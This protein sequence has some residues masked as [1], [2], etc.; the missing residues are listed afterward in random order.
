MTVSTNGRSHRSFHFW[1]CLWIWKWNRPSF[2]H[3]HS[4]SFSSLLLPVNIL[5]LLLASFSIPSLRV[6]TI[7]T[8]N[9]AMDDSVGKPNYKSKLSDRLLVS[10]FHFVNRFIRWDKLPPIIGA[11]N[12][13]ALRVELRQYNLHDGYASAT[14][15]GDPNSEPM[16]DKRF[17]NARNSDGKFN[18]VQMPL[19][20][21]TGMRLG[22]NFPRVLTPK[23]TEE[24]LWTPN[25]RML[26]Q[27]FMAR[28]A[29]IPAT[30]LNLLAAAWIQFQIH[31]WFFHESVSHNPW[32]TALVSV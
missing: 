32:W 4:T 18:S 9:F 23:P 12:L 25:P 31:D 27:R 19:M 21:C 13:E 2:P 3:I 5:S 17:E 28:K 30:T 26:S 7:E 22:R 6:S 20:G 16:T 11:L 1:F 15:Q 8:A 14:A 24:Q 10:F 29:F